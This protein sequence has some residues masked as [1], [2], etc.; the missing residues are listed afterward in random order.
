MKNDE[1]DRK[2]S[3]SKSVLIVI[4]IILV[5]F[6]LRPSLTAVGPLVSSIC[7]DLGISNGLAGLITTLPLMAF[8]VLSPL[9]PKIGQRVSNEV[10]ILLGLLVLLLG[11]LIRSAGLISTMF[12]GTA[13]VGLGIAICNV[14]LP[15]I[16]KQR[17]PN[18]VG[19]MTSLYST[20]MSV[21]AAFA[22]GVSIPLARGLGLGWQ[23]ALLVWGT[24]AV[25]AALCWIPQL[26][27]R[28]KLEDHRQSHMSHGSLWRSTIAWQVTCFM[29]LQSFLFYCTIA[30]LPDILTHGGF[31]DSTAGWL[32]FLV[33]LAG[34]PATFVT[35]TLAGR[36]TDQRLIVVVLGILYFG[37]MLGILF[38]GSIG[39]VS[40]YTVLVGLGQGSTISLALAFLGLRTA[41]AKQ[42]AELS[43]MAQSIGYVL[44][45]I[46]PVLIGVL[47]DSIHSWT[48]PI[49]IL[50]VVIVLMFLAGLGAGCNKYV[51][52]GEHTP[53]V[54]K[55][56]DSRY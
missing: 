21:V 30:W 15:G 2:V 24:L 38:G 40:L 46:G 43:G 37:G 47:Y 26:L 41:S 12:I 6:N 44:A 51:L 42:A 9:A 56:Q 49:V 45:A 22:S 14:L 48:V 36:L 32:L 3:A 34:L 4:G 23:K 5:A 25:V 10:T 19:L 1:R 28:R 31:S 54:G 53:V 11:I 33:Q 18:K 27:N 39:M 55:D 52:A 16:V 8:A 50:L 29:G 20:S 13:C 7:A 35:P 17:F